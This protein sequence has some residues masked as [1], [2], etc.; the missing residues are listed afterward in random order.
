MFSFDN[1]KPG[2]TGAKYGAMIGFV[3]AGA[4]AFVSGAGPALSAVGAV[5]AAVS[6]GIGGGAIGL[7]AAY[8]HR[9]VKNLTAI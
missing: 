5:F 7:G 9:I 4:F 2:W 1:S 8:T 6:G 3:V